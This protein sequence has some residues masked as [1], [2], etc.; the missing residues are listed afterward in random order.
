MVANYTLV[1]K[2]PGN[3]TFTR[4]YNMAELQSTLGGKPLTINLEPAFTFTASTDMMFVDIGAEAAVL[5]VDW[6]DGVVEELVCYSCRLEHYYDSY[7][8]HDVAITGNL[9]GITALSFTSG[10]A[11]TS[12]ISLEHLPE[13][14][15]F[16]MA[17]TGSPSYVNLLA[18]TKIE[19]INVGYSYVTSFSVPE[20]APINHV[21]VANLEPYNFDSASLNEIIHRVYASAVA[22]N[23][24]GGF[25]ELGYFTFVAPISPEALHELE[26]L[27]DNYGWEIY[28]WQP[29]PEGS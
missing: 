8:E 15:S 14:R 18:N 26:V 23:R 17:F 6:G 12:A 27:R 13:L 21:S 16:T 11:S 5:S 4:S 7:Q 19:Y 2:S 25:L 22:D 29:Y 20:H 1:V 3:K 28:G 10:S 24:T 9:W